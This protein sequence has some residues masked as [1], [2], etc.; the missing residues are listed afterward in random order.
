[1]STVSVS[2]L[3]TRIHAISYACDDVLLFE[4][5][6]LDGQLLP[7]FTPGA[8]VDVHIPGGLSRSYSLLNDA[9]ERHRY[10]IGIK[11]EQ[12]SRGGSAWMHEMARPGGRLEIAGPR[13]HFALD[14]SA[15]HSVLIA[16]GIG[17]TPL[18]SMAQRLHALQRPW[19]LH[20]RARSRRAAPL[21]DEL[22]CAELASHVTTSFSDEAQG[23]RLDIVRIVAEAPPGAHFYCCGPVP[24]ME[25]FQQACSHLDPARVHL[26]YFAAKEEAATE[27]GYTVRLAKS[28]REVLVQ[29][30]ETI[31]ASL[32]AAG[33]AVPSSC[34]QGVCGACEM[35][36]LSGTPDHRDLVLSDTEKASGATMMICCSGSLS[37]ELVLDA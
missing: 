10:L 20:Y 29:P 11:R 37:A 12:A 14:E 30:G 5:R 36:V 33:V 28:G 9:A 19:T 8:H 31:L 34:Q 6:S 2:T 3:A 1:M 16:G 21:L 26:E 27:G 23:R 17:I 25:S 15:P 4:L 7:A 13:N 32:Q 35:R 24:M 18:W 22:A